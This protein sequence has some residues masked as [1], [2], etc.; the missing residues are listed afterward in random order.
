MVDLRGRWAIV[1]IGSTLSALALITA[2][3][4]LGVAEPTPPALHSPS[5]SVSSPN[6]SEAA[7]A[8]GIGG[9]RGA[10]GAAGVGMWNK[11]YANA[12]LG[13]RRQWD[14]V[15]WERIKGADF[16]N[17]LEVGAGWC[18]N[19]EMLI[20]L[21][22]HIWVTEVDPTAVQHCK[23]RFR[24]RQENGTANIDYIAVD[25]VSLSGVPSESITMIYQFDAGVHFHR[26]VIRQYIKEFARVLVPGG[27]G[28]FHHSNLG[29]VPDRVKNVEGRNGNP[30]SRTNMTATLFKQYAEEAGLE[31]LCQTMVDWAHYQKLDS[32]ARFWKPI[33]DKHFD[34]SCRGWLRMSR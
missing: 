25:G 24:A 15:I 9:L 7:A 23:D 34:E 28:F 32:F 1:G 13:M 29:A 3:K 4:R 6:S 21:A 33:P 14:T 18:R 10:G 12:E 31:M 11:Y 19:T 5:P 2:I 20:K 22:G 17:T 16:S 27:S 26:E 8:R 30:H